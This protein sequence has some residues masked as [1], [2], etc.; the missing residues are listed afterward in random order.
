MKIEITYADQYKAVCS[1]D[2]VDL[3]GLTVIYNGVTLNVLKPQINDDSCVHEEEMSFD[4]K[5]R[6]ILRYFSD[7]KAAEILKGFSG[8]EGIK[9]IEIKNAAFNLSVCI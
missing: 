3:V 2:G 8:F 5:I 4:E 6:V 9:Y 7:P 1:P